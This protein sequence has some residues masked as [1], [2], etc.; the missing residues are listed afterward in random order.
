MTTKTK[1]IIIQANEAGKKAITQ[2]CKLALKQIVVQASRE[3]NTIIS[4][5]QPLPKK[6]E[7]K[8]KKK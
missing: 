6:K 8:D 2:I 5:I 1:P 4:T 7:K 3:M